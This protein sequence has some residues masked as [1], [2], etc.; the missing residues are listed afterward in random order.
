MGKFR[1][2]F[3]SLIA[4]VCTSSL[5]ALGDPGSDIDENGNAREN[6]SAP[7]WSAVPINPVIQ[8]AWRLN[9]Q[10][11]YRGTEYSYVWNSGWGSTIRNFDSKRV[12]KASLSYISKKEP[13]A[14]TLEFAFVVRNDEGDTELLE[15]ESK[16][17]T[18]AATFT[19]DAMTERSYG[20]LVYLG[21]RWR[22]GASFQGWVARIVESGQVVYATGSN[23][24][25]AK[26]AGGQEMNVWI[27]HYLWQQSKK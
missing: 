14:A 3:G 19:F 5:F 4:T 20:R 11:V 7:A 13:P 10:L 1:I 24:E 22:K 27:E 8:S 6:K 18:P 26:K 21:D 12:V 17:A 9:A 25:L 15:Y 23:G 2:F 16:P